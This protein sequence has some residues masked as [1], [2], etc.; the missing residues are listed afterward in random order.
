MLSPSV[1]LFFNYPDVREG[2]ENA[3]NRAGDYLAY[4]LFQI[5]VTQAW[6]AEGKPVVPF[7]WLLYHGNS[8]PGS[9]SI[10]PHQAHALAIFPFLSGAD[11]VWLWDSINIGMT[12]DVDPNRFAI[13]EHYF[14]GVSRLAEHDAML[15]D[16]AVVLAPEPARDSMV[17]NSPVWRGVIN[18]GKILVAAHNPYAQHEH[19]EVTSFDVDYGGHPIATIWVDGLNTFL[20]VFD[21]PFDCDAGN[22]TVWLPPSEV[23]DLSFGPDTETLTWDEPQFPGGTPASLRYDTIRSDNPADWSDTAACVESD[24]DDRTADDPDRPVAGQAWYYLVR[25]VNDCPDDD[26]NAGSDSTGVPRNVRSCP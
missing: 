10:R 19:G 13:Y 5:E 26:G 4:L 14:Y 1:Y 18:D 25:A 21:L 22:D 23:P 9:P 15:E 16:D 24:D 3:W 6:N 11:G 12:P 8:E 20:G 17:A 2:N 7:E